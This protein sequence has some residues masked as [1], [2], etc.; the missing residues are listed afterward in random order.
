MIFRKAN[1]YDAND[2]AN[3]HYEMWH[4]IYHEKLSKTYLDHFNL[5]YRK[6]YWL[7]FINSNKT[8]YV[9]EE[10]LG[11]IDGFII[12]LIR[13]VTRAQNVGELNMSYIADNDEMEFHTKGLVLSCAKL[14]MK[15]NAD[16][17]YA[18]MD[19]ENPV[20]SI[21]LNMGAKETDAKVDRID[22]K[23]VIKM[24]IIFSDLKKLLEREVETLER[25]KFEF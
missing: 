25:M 3:V 1:I 5:D 11:G 4:K 10:K 12:P 13:R 20:T 15:N 19:R 22:T 7:S 17:M 9:V 6:K 18:W 8:V 2:I 21:L 24:K 23:D 16:E 14:F